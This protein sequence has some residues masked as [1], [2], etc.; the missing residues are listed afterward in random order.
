MTGDLIITE[1]LQGIRE[2]QKY[3]Q[4]KRVLC[5]LK[6]V[7][8]T[9]KPLAVR[10]ADNYRFLRQRGITIRKTIDVIIGTWCIANDFPLLH[11]DHDFDP[12]EQY[13]GL[14]VVR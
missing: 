10:A 4:I 13:L 1:V 12:M 7:R 14:K 11:N 6:Y 5:S 8:F 9:R 2:E 3:R